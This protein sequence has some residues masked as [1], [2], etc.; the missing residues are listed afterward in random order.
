M[1]RL[2]VR[3]DL[4]T[5]S[6]HIL[7][8]GYRVTFPSLED[9]AN[10]TWAREQWKGPPYDW[11]NSRSINRYFLFGNS[12]DGM[13]T[14][15]LVAPEVSV[16]DHVAAKLAAGQH[17]GPGFAQI[18]QSALRAGASTATGLSITNITVSFTASTGTLSIASPTQLLQIF[19]TKLLR[20]RSG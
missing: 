11:Q 20:T 15:S 14:G 18:L 16:H 2:E 1:G 19:D 6:N 3:C 17:D 4:P 5:G 8:P 9:I 7:T 10:P 13:W 12:T